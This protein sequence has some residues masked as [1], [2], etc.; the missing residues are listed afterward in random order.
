MSK[1][2]YTVQQPCHQQRFLALNYQII[3]SV[4]LVEKGSKI[5][6]VVF[7]VSGYGSRQTREISTTYT[8]LC[9]APNILPIAS[10]SRFHSITISPYLYLLNDF[11]GFTV[12][13]AFWMVDNAKGLVS[14]CDCL[15]RNKGYLVLIESQFSLN[16]LFVNIFEVKAF[17]ENG[18]TIWKRVF[19]F[20]LLK[21]VE[22]LW[23]RQ[24][25]PYRKK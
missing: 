4:L 20:L 1:T 14:T 7:Q 17:L 13:L 3:F 11:F 16:C 10:L 21:I 5:Q 8:C 12:E 18:C 15:L 6:K 19:M 25:Y 2:H 9:P 23:E 24:A 22:R